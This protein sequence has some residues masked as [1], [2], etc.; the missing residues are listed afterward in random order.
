MLV[1]FSRFQLILLACISYLDV[2]INFERQF[3]KCPRPGGGGGLGGG[4]PIQL[5]GLT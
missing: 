1:C 4:N 2:R 5:C 3:L